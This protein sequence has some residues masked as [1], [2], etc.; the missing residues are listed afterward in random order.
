MRLCPVGYKEGLTPTVKYLETNM[1]IERESVARIHD[2][3][4]QIST[5]R[6]SEMEEGRIYQRGLHGR[7]RLET[8]KEM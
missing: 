1:R 8:L 2:T 4:Y 6:H 7:G 3:C 5:G